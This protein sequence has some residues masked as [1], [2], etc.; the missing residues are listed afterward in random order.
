[1]K[2]QALSFWRSSRGV[3]IPLTFLLLFVSLTLAVTITYYIAVAKV[4]SK[5]ALLKSA[6]SKQGIL[7]LND[8]IFSVAWS[9]GSS[10]I[11]YFDDYGG[12]FHCEPTERRL[13]IN[14]MDDMG[15]SEVVFNAS[16]GKLVYQLAS[17]ES[18]SQYFLKGD[19]RL[20]V[21][22]TTSSLAQIYVSA[23][24]ERQ[25][26]SL[27]YRPYATISQNGLEGKKPQN[28]IRIYIISLS[29]SPSFS[30][31]GNFKLKISCL[32]VTYTTYT[33][34][35]SYSIGSLN[36]KA[37]VEN[38]QTTVSLPIS[39]ISEGAIIRLE[40]LTCHICLQKAGET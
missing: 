35:F 39:S 33:Y 26:I 1:M 24:T 31:S 16:I 7:Y 13:T 2:K 34:N 14:V 19:E 38:A 25:E 36:I 9:P 32:N 15:F 23:G 18:P 5:A 17:S 29:S 8:N 40:L 22:Q 37:S 3:A 28:T 30:V 6:Q 12:H 27:W 4:T 10:R 11:Y 20:I 21:N